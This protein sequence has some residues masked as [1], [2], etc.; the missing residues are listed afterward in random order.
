VMALGIRREKRRRGFGARR[1][2]RE[3]GI[4]C[5]EVI[6]LKKRRER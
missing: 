1:Q 5:L 2:R 4:D 6:L 3:T